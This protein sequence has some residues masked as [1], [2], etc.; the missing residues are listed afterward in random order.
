MKKESLTWNE[1]SAVIKLYGELGIEDLDIIDED[2]SH[3]VLTF[4]TFSDGDEYAWYM[5]G[6]DDVAINMRTGRILTG[7]DIQLRDLF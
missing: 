6:D 7:R 1:K 3:G 4:N 5:Y 2:I